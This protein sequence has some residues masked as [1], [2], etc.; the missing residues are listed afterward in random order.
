[1]KSSGESEYNFDFNNSP[2]VIIPNIKANY[3]E[4]MKYKSPSS[5]HSYADQFYNS[6]VSANQKKNFIDSNK[7]IVK[8][9]QFLKAVG[10]DFDRLSK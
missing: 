5:I 2:P 6:I 7:K 1:M 8:K 3:L 4:E 9:I 10:K